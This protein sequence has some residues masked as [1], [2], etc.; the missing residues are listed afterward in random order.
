M[1]ICLTLTDID[2]SVTRDVVAIIGTF[3]ALVIAALGLST[4]NRQLRGTSEYDTAKRAILLTYKVQ[5]EI[6]NV[7][8]PMIFLDKDEVESGRRLEE[9]QRI[10]DER[11]RALYEKWTDLQAV[12]LEAKVIWGERAS[13]CFDEMQKVIGKL[14]SAIWMHFWLKGAYAAPG[15][16]VDR[17]PER[18]VENNRIV[19]YESEKDEFSVKIDSSVESV[20]KFFKRKTKIGKET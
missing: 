1:N 7:R 9:E 12:R 11:M 18:R 4:W 14:R 20:E 19:Y 15:A 6:Q 16:E 17:T 13:E 2:W 3:G 10:Y 5:Q 8:S